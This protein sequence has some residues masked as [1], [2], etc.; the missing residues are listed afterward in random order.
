MSQHR[1][2][3]FGAGDRGAAEALGLVVIAP[4]MILL[5]LLVVLLGRDVDARAIVRSAAEAGAQAAALERDSTSSSAA[6]QAVVAAM[7]TD[8]TCRRHEA[9]VEI[10]APD[11]QGRS[12][13]AVSVI[14]WV[15]NDGVEVLRSDGKTYSAVAY[16]TIDP[17][18]SDDLP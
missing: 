1:S 3:R 8:G 4:G 15:A 6:A 5:A 18:R 7:L 11:A 16:A 12:A 10:A 14:C 9:A 2:G 17:Y 13:V